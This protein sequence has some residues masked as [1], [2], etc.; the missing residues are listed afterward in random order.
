MKLLEF[1]FLCLLARKIIQLSN[2]NTFIVRNHGQMPKKTQSALTSS[3]FFIRCYSKR[4]AIFNRY[5]VRRFPFFPVVPSRIITFHFKAW[6]LS[7]Q[8]LITRLDPHDS[9][10][11]N[12]Y[13]KR[14]IE[15]GCKRVCTEKELSEK[16]CLNLKESK[17]KRNGPWN[18]REIQL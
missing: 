12:R 15:I 1:L 6:L 4:K 9:R 13:A 14:R 17:S 7:E 11:K 8:C 18:W 10:Q 3:L 16:R 2:P 5:E